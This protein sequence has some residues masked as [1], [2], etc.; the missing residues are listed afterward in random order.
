MNLLEKVHGSYIHNRRARILSRQLSQLLPDRGRILDIGC[1][2]GLLGSLL[3]QEKPNTSITGVEVMLRKETHI[4]VEIFDGHR[5]PFDDDAFEA[6]MLVDVLHHTDGPDA[7]LREAV[8][9]ARDSIVIKDHIN[10]GL[11]AETTLRL[12]DRISNCRHDVALPHNYWSRQKWLDTFAALNLN[13]EAWMDHLGLYPL[14][15][16]WI[17]G[18]SLHFIA[19]LRRVDQRIA[20]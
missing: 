3:Q 19:K 14:P 18:R 6:V 7:L 12:M 4:P 10:D 15:L 8:R 20:A 17:F 1:G 5:V 16:D 13:V 11:G 9:V 2:D